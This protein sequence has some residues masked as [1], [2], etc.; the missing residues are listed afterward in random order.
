MRVNTKQPNNVPRQHI[1]HDTRPNNARPTYSYTQE[2]QYQEKRT[3]NNNYPTKTIPEILYD[4]KTF[5]YTHQYVFLIFSIIG[6][7]L[8]M[9]INKYISIGFSIICLYAAVK[10]DNNYETYNNWIIYLAALL[11]IIVPFIY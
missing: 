1:P 6:I 7:I 5:L 11:G 4:I 2:K 3:H 10:A 9:L 8:A